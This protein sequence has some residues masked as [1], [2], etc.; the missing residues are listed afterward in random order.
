MSWWDYETVRQKKM[1]I[2]EAALRLWTGIFLGE[3]MRLENTQDP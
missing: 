3:N 1:Q 2:E